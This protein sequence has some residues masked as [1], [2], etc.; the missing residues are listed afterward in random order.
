MPLAIV[1][2]LANGSANRDPDS[3][4]FAIGAQPL[5]CTLTMRGNLGFVPS[6]HALVGRGDRR[7]QPPQLAQF[8]KRLPHADQ[9]RAAASRIQNHV[10]ELPV[11]LLG[12]FQAHRLLALD[13]IRLLECREI[14][15][16]H[17]LFALAHD[18]AAVGDESVDEER[19]RTGQPGLVDVHGG[20]VLRHED[21]RFQTSSRGIGRRRAT[22]VSG[23]GQRHATDSEVLRHR[24]GHRQT[25]ALEAPR[26]QMRFVLDPQLVEPKSRGHS[27]ATQQ[28]RL[29]FTERH[30]F[31]L[32]RDRQQFAIPPHVERSLTQFLFC[33]RSPHGRQ[34]IPHPQRPVLVQSLQSIGGEHGPVD[35]GFEV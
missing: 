30:G 14:E 20:R 6:P 10:G 7:R 34:V 15:P 33:E 23:R 4:A 25:T 29:A 11:E 22:R 32:E 28:W 9:A 24:D 35:G 3:N 2:A 5:D 17:A 12:Q 1:A 16:V 8:L 21:V 27:V 26:R 18:P 19:L 31:H 13:A